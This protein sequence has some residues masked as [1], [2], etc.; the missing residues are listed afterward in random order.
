MKILYFAWLREK[1]G[2]A[3]EDLTPPDGVNTVGTLVEWLKE[4]SPGHAEAFADGALVKAAV[5]QE[6]ARFDGGVAMGRGGGDH[7]DTVAGPELAVAVDNQRFLK[8]PA[9]PGLGLDFG[10]RL[11]GH[12]R[13]MFQRHRLDRLVAGDIADQADKA[14]NAADAVISFGKALHLLSDVEI[15]RLHPDHA[16]ILRPPS[17]P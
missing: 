6:L 12:F 7:D 2:V 1:A 10:Q 16:F 11:F 3:E 9:A 14:A 5:N 13:I 15:V 17:V 4:Q 8:G